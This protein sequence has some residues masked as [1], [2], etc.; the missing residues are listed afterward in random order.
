MEITTDDPQGQFEGGGDAANH[1]PR[2]PRTSRSSSKGSATGPWVRGARGVLAE[3]L[4]RQRRPMLLIDLT[5]VTFIDAAGRACLAEMHREGAEFIAPDCL[6]KATVAEIT[7]TTGPSAGVRSDAIL[8][9]ADQRGNI[10]MESTV[11]KNS[12]LISEAPPTPAGA[13]TA[14]AQDGSTPPSADGPAHPDH[15]AA[16]PS[17]DRSSVARLPAA[18][19]PSALAKMAAAGGGVAGLAVGGYLLAPAVETALNTVSTD[20]AYVNGYVTLVRS[21]VPG[22]VA[23]VLVHDNYRVQRGTLLVQLDKEPYQVQVELKKRPGP[24]RGRPQGRR[25]AGPGQPW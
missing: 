22:Q 14:E 10:N 8:A 9:P 21:R 19:P 6:T 24:R 3:T 5:G 17:T 15:Q 1:G 12:D 18:W 16:D 25:S 2:Q 11:H 23:R 7:Q 4:T 20:D 13:A